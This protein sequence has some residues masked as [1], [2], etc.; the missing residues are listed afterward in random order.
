MKNESPPDGGA[1][2]RKWRFALAICLLAALLLI[3]GC[4]TVPADLGRGEVNVLLAERGQE[5]VLPAGGEGA[6]ELLDS[7]TAVPLT[8]Q[9]A[10]RITFLNNPALSAEIAR[11]GFGAAE[12]YEAGRISNPVFSAA[13]LDASVD[14]MG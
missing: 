9:S 5:N 4:T 6:T 12:V 10:V 13:F 11:L 1:G 8:P 7:L 14:Y 3:G 2:C